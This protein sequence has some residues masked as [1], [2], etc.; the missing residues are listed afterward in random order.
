MKVE[1]C[2]TENTISD[3]FAEPSKGKLFKMFPNRILNL[4]EED[5][6]KMKN[7]KKLARMEARIENSNRAKSVKSAH[8]GDVKSKEVGSLNTVN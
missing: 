8:K 4:R 6:R 7:S 2:S 3:F 5:I 1:Y